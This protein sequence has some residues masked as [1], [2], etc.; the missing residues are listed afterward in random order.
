VRY[1]AEVALGE[2]AGVGL[3]GLRAAGQRCP[4]LLDMASVRGVLVAT[5][6]V[7]AACRTSS[8]T[9]TLGQRGVSGTSNPLIA[10]SASAGI[11]TVPSTT[12]PLGPD[13][14]TAA[15]KITSEI[16]TLFGYGPSLDAKLAIIAD[17][18]GL[19]SVVAQGMADPRAPVL[20]VRVTDIVLTSPSS[21]VA[22]IDFFLKGMP[23]A[24]GSKLEFG[25][26]GGVWTATRFSYCALLLTG[27]LHC[28]T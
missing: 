15:A 27:G 4:V 6:F 17:G 11:P 21:A 13:P 3:N 1:V 10:G 2:G 12:M 22:T 9:V 24:L 23:A 20:S 26:I 25:L 8:G 7:A 18:V 14:A 28:P 19:R 16:V 5:I